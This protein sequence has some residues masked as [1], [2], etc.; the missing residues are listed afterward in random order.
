MGT[1]LGARGREG[2]PARVAPSD[3]LDGDVLRAVGEF[4]CKDG[5]GDGGQTCDSA[6]DVVAVKVGAVV[7][8][9]GLE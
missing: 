6:L 9:W 1:G 3:E 4:L 8:A 2:V 7:C 5:C